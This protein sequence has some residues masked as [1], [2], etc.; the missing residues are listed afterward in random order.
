MV[1]VI[2]VDPVDN[3]EIIPVAD[4]MVATE[5]L[6]LDHTE[7]PVISDKVVPEPAQTVVVPVIG[8]GNGFTV[9]TSVLET[10]PQ[11]LDTE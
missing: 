9:T 4:P 5:G 8:E 1:K 7:V 2:I 3:P 11:L 6:L 10:V